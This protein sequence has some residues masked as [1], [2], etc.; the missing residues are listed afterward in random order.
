[1]TRATIDRVLA[2]ARA[3]LVRLSAVDAMQATRTGARL[4]D[5]RTTEQVLE[6]GRLPGALEVGLNVLE[7]RLDPTSASRHPDAP[8][9]E[10]LVV[11]VCAQGY[12]SSLAAVRLQQLGF[13]R[14]T[15]L[16]GGVEA[17]RAAGLPLLPVAP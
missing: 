5:V 11:V 3:R 14:A 16:V 8:G 10:D 2:E 9:L 17:W 7:W 12:S 15:D 13:D 1:M 6:A 4:V